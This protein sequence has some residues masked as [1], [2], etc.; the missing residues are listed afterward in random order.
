MERTAPTAYGNMDIV[1]GHC[2]KTTT[3]RL[4]VGPDGRA[5]FS[6]WC[7]HCGRRTRVSI[8]VESER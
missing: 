5:D 2:M 6:L 8:M 7:E 3:H 4:E 1:C